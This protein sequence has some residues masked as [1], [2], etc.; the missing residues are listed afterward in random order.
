MKKNIV[1]IC[2][3]LMFGL[4]GFAAGIYALPILTAPQA[5]SEQLIADMARSAVFRRFR[6]ATVAVLALLYQ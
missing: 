5:P 3:H 2:S 4:A 1:L 6:A